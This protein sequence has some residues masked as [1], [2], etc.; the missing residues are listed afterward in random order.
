M[1]CAGTGVATGCMPMARTL[2]H[3]SMA[4]RSVGSETLMPHRPSPRK[5]WLSLATT[6]MPSPGPPAERIRPRQAA[7]AAAAAASQSAITEKRAGQEERC[8]QEW[9]GQRQQS[10]FSRRLCTQQTT[11][12]SRTLVSMPRVARRLALS[13]P[14]TGLWQR[15]A[16]GW[17]SARRWGMWQVRARAR[18]CACVAW[19]C[20]DC[21][22]ANW[23]WWWS[24]WLMGAANSSTRC[25]GW[26]APNPI[27]AV[28]ST[29]A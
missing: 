26:P 23:Q 1:D 7:G 11:Q 3:S 5:R 25:T 6:S 8:P 15:Q 12:E 21:V 27:R 24:M 19:L 13:S 16:S 2:P 29:C 22:Y 20:I 9:H 28:S 4:S 14:F 18:A 17:W 10:R